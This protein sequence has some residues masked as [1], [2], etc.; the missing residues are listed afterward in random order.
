M[1]GVDSMKI[2]ICDDEQL[3]IDRLYGRIKQR[4]ANTADDCV[5]TFHSGEE[6]CEQYRER[7]TPYDI[8]FLDIEMKELNGIETARRI[9]KTDKSVLI[10]FLTSHQNFA[11]DG[12]E[13]KAFRY[14]LKSEPT[15]VFTRHLDEVFKEY[16]C[17]NKTMLIK[18]KD[19]KIPLRF[20][21]IHFIEIFNRIINVHTADK[22]YEY[23]AKLTDL[24]NE[25]AGCS[26]VRTNKSV[27]VNL[28]QIERL[29]GNYVYLKNGRNL[30]L[31][32]RYKP[33]I[34]RAFVE[35]LIGR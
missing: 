20:D 29:E 35:H 19:T 7:K 32:R 27:L 28:A 33:T 3:C 6:L 8:V 24:E 12:Y 2:A 11:V 21:D 31:S 9:R 15:P 26:F 13:V 34:E 5:E 18:T 23:Y 10:V 22:T 25:L 4:F 16:H 14:I 1:S 17:G 30:P